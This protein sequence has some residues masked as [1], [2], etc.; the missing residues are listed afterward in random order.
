MHA[1]GSHDKA[2]DKWEELRKSN[3]TWD[4]FQ[5]WFY[6]AEEKFNVKRNVHNKKGSL[7][8]DNVATH[9]DNEKVPEDDQI[10]ISKMDTC[11]DNLAAAAETYFFW[12][13]SE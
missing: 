13:F 7:N 5:D 12:S 8:H 3:Q 6:N 1:R 2:L 9:G 11:L 4:M 10:D